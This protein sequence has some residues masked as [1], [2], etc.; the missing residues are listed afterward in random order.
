MVTIKTKP[1][2]TEICKKMCLLFFNFMQYFLS[3]S[4]IHGFNHLAERNRHPFEKFIWLLAVSSAIYGTGIL[5]SL[6]LMRYQGNPTVISMERDRFSWNTSFPGATI[7][8][9]FKV[10]EQLMEEYIEKS[11]E[12]NKT[13]LQEFI[14]SL[15]N[16][17]YENFDK[18]VKYDKIKS[19]DYLDLLL[20]LQFEFKPS[21]S[22][23]GINGQQY[24]LQ[25]VISEKGICYAFNSQLAIYNSPE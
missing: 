8:P 6:T 17:T 9:S 5:S 4:T 22:N 1:K 14:L 20:N 3:T 21:V 23:S 11:T 16:A 12:T 7:C 13:L 18:V 10:N 2:L 24:T 19:E 15:A 25:K